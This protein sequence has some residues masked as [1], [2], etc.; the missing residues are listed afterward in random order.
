MISVLIPSRGRPEHLSKA[1]ASLWSTATNP[2]DVVVAV[3][4]D[5]PETK[6]I[7]LNWGA[8]VV[9]APERFG[10]TGLYKYF[11]LMAHQ[12]TG[13]WLVL[14]DDQSIMTTI[15]WDLMIERLPDNVIVGDLQNHFSPQLCCFPAVR[16]DAVQAIDCFSYET[17]HVDTFWETIGRHLQAIQPVPAY[18]HHERP[19]ITGIEAD[20]T[21]QES[22]AGMRVSDFYSSE[23]QQRMHDAAERIRSVCLQH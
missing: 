11:N 3:D 4:P 12:A 20:T 18:V 14:W 13:D 15:L 8:T 5:D 6:Q 1:I 2:V 16:A 22:R 7:A 21:H 19:D 17:P 9:V 23:F 10:Y